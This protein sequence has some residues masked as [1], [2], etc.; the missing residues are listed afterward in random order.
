M[1]QCAP[2]QAGVAIRSVPP[3]RLSEPVGQRHRALLLI[4]DRGPERVTPRLAR[5]VLDRLLVPVAQVE[6][7][8]YHLG[9]STLAE[10]AATATAFA[11]LLPPLGNLSNAYY[12]VH[13]R[14]ND[15][16]V[17]AR[18]ALKS[19]FPEVDFAQFAFTGHVLR[20]LAVTCP[21]RFAMVRHEVATTWELRVQLLLQRL[22][23][24]GVLIDLPA[25]AWLPRPPIRGEGRRRL[26]LDPDDRGTGAAALRAMLTTVRR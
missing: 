21:E 24:R 18:P 15:R 9:D 8:D 23:T 11:L 12:T 7:V 26:A 25:P 4:G 17:R 19:L 16:F 3:R 6:G 22:P 2:N 13:P 10:T 5:R 20:A 14:R 1:Q